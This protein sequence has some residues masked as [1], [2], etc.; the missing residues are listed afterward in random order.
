MR[1]SRRCATLAM[2]VPSP[3]EVAIGT[4]Q[5]YA[6]SSYSCTPLALRTLY[7]SHK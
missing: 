5:A 6:V 7:G 4:E 3:H 1:H 2:P